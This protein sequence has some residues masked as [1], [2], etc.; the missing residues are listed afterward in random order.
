MTQESRAEAEADALADDAAVIQLSR[1]EPELFTVLFRRHAP[2]I[3][4][5]VVRRLGPDAADDI[6]AET[7]LLAFRQ[8]DS[9]DQTRVDARPWLYGIATNLIGRHRRAE[10]RLYR[11]LARTGADPVTESFTDQVDDRVSAGT[12][13]R[14]LAAG[15]ARLPEELRDT[16]LL[17]AWGDLTY[18]EAATALGVPVGTVRSR[19]SRAEANCAGPSAA[20]TRQLTTRSR[21][22]ERDRPAHPLPGR[23]PARR[24]TACRAVVPRRTA[25]RPQ[26]RTSRFSASPCPGSGRGM[27]ARMATGRHRVRSRRSRSGDSGGGPAGCPPVL[28]VQL[29]ADRASAAALAQPAVSP[30]QWVYRVTEWSWSGPNAPKGEL[31]THLDPYWEP[32]DG[33]VTYGGSHTVPGLGSDIPATP[34]SGRCR[35]T[36]PPWTRTSSAPGAKRTRHRTFRSCR[37]SPRSKA[38]SPTTCCRRRSRRRC[39]RRWPSFPASRSTATSP[40]STARPASHSCCRPPRRAQRRDHPQPV[41]LRAHCPSVRG[42]QRVFVETAVVRMVFVGAPGSTQPSR[43]P[44]TAAELLA[45]QAALAVTINDPQTRPLTIF[46]VV[47]SAWILRELATP[48]GDKA[49]WATG[50]DSKQA[51]YVNGK[52]EVCSRSAAC[53]TSTQWL[54]PAGPSF[55]LINPRISLQ[56]CPAPCRSCSRRSTRTPRDAPTWRATAT[57]STRSS[58]WPRLRRPDG[59]LLVPGSRPTSPGS[60][61]RT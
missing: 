13:S 54:M 40:P 26:S 18:A 38:C 35:A 4:R 31:G 37:R 51:G 6:V 60:R 1:R 57:P 50:D 44:P 46:S 17:V 11:A 10:I 53:A 22:N 45:E 42:R 5:Y 15:L 14:R 7:F 27:A 34:S 12:A 30:G 23:G 49:V 8:R 61:S 56:A 55:A 59:R 25:S 21:R 43:T 24:H 39:T 33:I 9:Y 52:L 47:P 58:T 29:L 41:L 48:S 32:A 36:R 19:V 28:T 16:L 3:Q 2:Y 20:P